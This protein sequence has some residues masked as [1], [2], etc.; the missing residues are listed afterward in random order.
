MEDVYARKFTEL[1][2]N[3]A[4]C[5]CCEKLALV[6][7]WKDTDGY[8]EAICLRCLADA[9]ASVQLQDGTAAAN[10]LRKLADDL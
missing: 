4:V 5:N 1:R 6:V 8:Y 7:Q 10:E 2:C 9:V 3:E